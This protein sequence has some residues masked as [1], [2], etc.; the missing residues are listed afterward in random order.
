M[1]RLWQDIKAEKL[2]N[3]IF[4]R[5]Y[6]FYHSKEEIIETL[7]AY[8]KEKSMTQAKF[9]RKAGVSPETIVAFENGLLEAG[10]SLSSRI[11][12]TIFADRSV[13]FSDRIINETAVK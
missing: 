2:K 7:L 12:N 1:S 13:N 8:R 10:T 3:P 11:V 6:D 4:K 5:Y 9:A